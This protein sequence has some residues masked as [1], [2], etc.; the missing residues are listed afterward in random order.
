MEVLVFLFFS[1][2]FGDNLSLSSDTQSSH[3]GDKHSD[4]LQQQ[5]QAV[6]LRWKKQQ[7]NGL[8]TTTKF[9]PLF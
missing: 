7:Q 4:I 1:S 8:C 2:F 9:F 3:I 5:V 6:N